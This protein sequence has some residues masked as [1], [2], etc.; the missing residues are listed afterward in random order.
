M[1]VAVADMFAFVK[2]RCKNMSIFI[3][4]PVLNNGAF[5]CAD[6]MNLVKPAIQKINNTLRLPLTPLSQSAHAEV[7]AAMRHAGVIS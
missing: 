7:E 6:L 1:I 3:D 2:V 4:S 5:A